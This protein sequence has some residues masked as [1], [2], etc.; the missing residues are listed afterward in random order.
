MD[1]EA[2]HTLAL[3]TIKG[4]GTVGCRQLLEEY[5]SATEIFKQA[6]TLNERLKTIFADT[7]LALKRAEEELNFCRKNN[8]RV[9]CYTQPDYPL[10][11]KQCDD[12][13]ISLFYKGNTD[14]NARHIVAVVGTR[15]ISEYGK[16]LCHNFC[17]DLAEI[18]PDSLII[19]GLAYGV[20]IHAHRE[21]L[22]VGLP[23]LGILAHGL[24]RIYPSSHRETAK[25]MLSHGGLLTEYMTQTIPEKGNFVRR[26][27]IVAGMADATIVVE[28]AAKGG[29]LITAQLAQDYN[30]DVFAFP[31]RTHDVYSEGCNQLIRKNG[32][33]LI[34]S[35]ADFAEAMGWARPESKQP[36]QRK[37]FP[38]LTAEQEAI[39]KTLQGNDG[40][41]INQIVVESNLPIQKV[42]ALLFDLEMDGLVKA[43]AGGRYRLLI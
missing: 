18:L 1:N 2:L 39:C 15:H 43:L 25:Q 9:L 5:G 23:T 34:T 13:P 29:S 36:I 3:S 11:L 10:R 14:L 40:K 6:P 33:A 17:K 12:A 20:D 19:S 37:L 24:D 28:S 7:S 22:K 42:S 35:A 21:A 27:R 4:L 32:A 16:D 31:G 26:N 38:E 30:R 41:Q 8:I